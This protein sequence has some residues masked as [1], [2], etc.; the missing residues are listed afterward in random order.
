VHFDLFKVGH[1]E[2]IESISDEDF[3]RAVEL[4]LDVATKKVGASKWPHIVA[5]MR[6]AQLAPPSP[7]TLEQEWSRFCSAWRRR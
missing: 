3:L 2:H 4:W 5:M 6:K 1:P 7:K